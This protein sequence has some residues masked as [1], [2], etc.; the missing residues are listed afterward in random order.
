MKIWMTGGGGFVGSNIVRQ[1]LAQHHHVTTTVHSFQSPSTAA[2][3]TD[4]V[5][6]KDGIAV[7]RSI[8]QCRPDALIHC[9]IL[10]DLANLYADRRSG[11]DAYVTSSRTIV[12]LAKEFDIPMV[13]VSTD[14][15]F[16]G[17]QG[18][19]DESTPPNPINIYGML[20]LASEMVVLEHG[21]AVARVSGVNGVHYA[22]PNMP[23]E[24][25][26]G[27]GFF[28]ASL[29]DSLRAKKSFS[30][31][32]DPAINMIATPSL[33]SDSADMILE[34]AAN[35][36]SGVFH[37]CGAES[38]GRLDLAK[39]ACKVF[40]LDES[41]LHTS[42]PVWGE[43]PRFL[44][45]HDTSITAPRTTAILGRKLLPLNDMLERFRGEYVA[46]LGEK[47]WQ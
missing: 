44:V 38:V 25:D 33:A 14:W 7:R 2:F 15:V 36:Y 28:V 41:L 42:A 46:F 5:D 27:F 22:R 24:Q 18:G 40:E 4:R 20:K 29:V 6:M 17:T 32:S 34:I 1:A 9:A 16:D 43:G 19:A 12:H 31:W 30:V 10:N 37:C 8:E 26:Q 47:G 23:R 11:W 35:R 39:A 3:R 21:G 45:P 13:L